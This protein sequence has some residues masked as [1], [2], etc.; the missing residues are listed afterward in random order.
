MNDQ[1]ERFER[2]FEVFEMPEPARERMWIRR[3]RKRRNQRLAAGALGVSI[4]L[5]GALIASR[6]I[7]LSAANVDRSATSVDDRI[8]FSRT[9]RT[10]EIRYFVA[11]ADGSGE[12]PF[13]QGNEFEGRQVSPDGSQLAI[14][15]PNE[16]GVLA[17][18]TVDI[19][20]T[21][22]RL[23]GNPDP[24]LNLAC[25]VW[26]PVDRMA[27]EGWDD[28][29][30]SR[31]GIY[32]VRATDGSDPQRLTRHRDVPCEYSPDGTR[33]AFI[34]TEAD[35][36]VGT[37]MLMDAEGGD[38]RALLGGVTL[39]GAPIPCDWSPDGRSI[40]VTSDGEL[41]VV[42]LGGEASPIEGDR[43]GGYS[44]GARWSS[45]G[46]HVLFSMTLEADDFDV[47]TV[48]ADGT[49]LTR[50]IDTELPEVATGWLP[51]APIG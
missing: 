22:F 4:V 7:D 28:S 26:A 51:G 16:T 29:D 37:L 14:V 33:L 44:L 1:R 12:T 30:P 31:D 39:S 35:D 38:A 8:L 41:I 17:G 47:Y 20:G 3:D 23:F 9:S 45:N 11:S 2:A 10:G 13:A 42:T 32:T 36:T 18:G 48:A 19:D 27:C 24:T 49:E 15:G 40:L 34:R 50:V 6:V 25:G 46:E 43:L 5:A 21:G